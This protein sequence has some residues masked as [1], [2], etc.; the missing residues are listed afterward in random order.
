[1]QK[2]DSNTSSS[3]QFKIQ[4]MR[5]T[6]ERL[7]EEV[8]VEVNDGNPRTADVSQTYNNDKRFSLVNQ[9]STAQLS[10]NSGVD[11]SVSPQVQT[12]AD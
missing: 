12:F 9:L 3:M 7:P 10:K 8:H 11:P 4:K 2:K 1:M 5:K 6:T